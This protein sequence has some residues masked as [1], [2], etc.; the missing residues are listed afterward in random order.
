M[1][2]RFGW[3]RG[4]VLLFAGLLLVSG[5]SFAQQGG[6]PGGGGGWMVA[7]AQRMVPVESVLTFL[8][9]DAKVN[10]DDDRLVKVR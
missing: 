5:A 2:R 7:M 3:I 8:A 4:A 6:G 10:L 1:M 9:F